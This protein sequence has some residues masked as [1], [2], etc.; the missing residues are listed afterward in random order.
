MARGGGAGDSPLQRDE[1]ASASG[2]S[3]SAGG[4][5][6]AGDVEEASAGAWG[7]SC[8]P[9]AGFAAPSLD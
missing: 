1:E 8:A 4:S 6:P 3:R 9:P 7:F 5:G 2:V